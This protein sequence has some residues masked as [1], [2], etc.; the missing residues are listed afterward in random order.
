MKLR[1]LVGILTMTSLMAPL[2][3]GAFPAR[4]QTRTAAG[5][6][7]KEYK[8][9]FDEAAPVSVE[10]F[11]RWSLP[12][13][14]GYMGV[15]VFGGVETEL[16][17]VTEN[18]VFNP[19][20]S[21]KGTLVEDA[22][23]GTKIY[24]NDFG[25]ER[26]DSSSG[27]LNLFAKT[28]IDF[29]G[30]AE[31][32]AVNYRRELS[33]DDSK[34]TVRY[35]IDGTT[36]TREYFSSYPDKVTV[37]RLTAT[38]SGKLNFTLRPE[39]P[40]CYD[41][42]SDEVKYSYLNTPGDGITKTGTVTAAGDTITLKGTMNYFG[43][44][45]EGLYKVIPTGGSMT[46]ANDENGKNGT[47]T[48]EG[49]DSALILLAVGTNYDYDYITFDNA[50][51]MLD[52]A[53]DPHEKV[54]GYLDAAAEK[55]YDQLLAAHLKD[56]RGFFDR[57]DLDLGGVYD[58]TVPTD[59][60]VGSY[61]NGTAA[62]DRYLEELTFQFG[63]YLLIS[64]SREGCLP[65]NLQ[66]IWNYADSAAWS[67][68]YWHNINIQMNYWPAFNT[69]LAE[70]FRSYADYNEAMRERA[71]AN[72]DSYLNAIQSPTAAPAGTGE[73]GY[74]IGTGCNPYKCASAPVTG[75]SGPGTGAFTSLLFWDWY[76]Y[77]MDE[78]VL[79]DH[80]YPAV[81]G[82]A[83]FLSKTL[84]E[85]E[86]GKWLV[87]NS[88]SP[89]NGVNNVYVQS[90]G[91]AFDQQMVYANHMAV[92][93]A[94]EAL[95]YTEEDAPIL[96]VIRE[97]IDRL[98]PVNIGYSGQV[99]EYREENYYGEFGEKNHRHISQLV[100]VYPA[101]V[102]NGDTKAWLDA[103]AVSLENRGYTNIGWGVIHRMLCW[104]R[105]HDGEKAFE[106]LQLMM[107]EHLGYSL[108]SNY[109]N[110]TYAK[111]A[112]N[113]FQ[114]EANF[115]CTAA[116]AEM[117]VQS[118][119]GYLEF[120][121]ALPETWAN[122]SFRGLTTRGNFAVDAVW[123]NG[124]AETLGI[125]SGSGGT[126]KV[127]Y[128]NLANAA[129]KDSAGDPV[130]F[131]VESRD[132]ISFETAAG[133]TYTIT[134]IPSHTPGL[135]AP[136]E[137]TLT[138]DTGD[139]MTL[140]WT[141][142]EGASG[143]NVYR[144]VNDAPDYELV[145]EG[146]TG[147]GY[148]YE[149]TD[150]QGKD[151]VTLRVTAVAPDGTESKSALAYSLPVTAAESAV[152]YLF[153]E[154]D[155]QLEVEA[156]ENATE[157]RAYANGAPVAVSPY[158]VIAVRN[159][160]PSAEYSVSAVV[161]GRESA[162]VRAAV[163]HAAGEDNVLLNRP[164]TLEGRSNW[165]SGYEG[166]YG[167][168]GD[169][170][171]PA[172]WNVP[173][174]WSVSSG[175]SPYSVTADLKGICKL[176]TMKI[177][178]WNSGSDPATRSPNT[179]VEVLTPEGDWVTVREGFPLTK[180]SVTAVEMG[181][182]LASKVRWTFNNDAYDPSH[183][184]YSATASIAE[185]T[186]TGETIDAVNKID[187]LEAVCDYAEQNVASSGFTG[188]QVAYLLA[189]P[190][191]KRVLADKDADQD[192]V[193]KAARAL[194]KAAVG[195][196]L[197]LDR[198]VV[199]G[200]TVISDNYKMEYMVDGDLSTRMA[201]SGKTK[202]DPMNIG[203]TVELDGLYYLDGVFVQEFLNN[204]QRTEGG[205]VTIEVSANG[206]DWTTVL[207]GGSLREYRDGVPASSCSNTAFFFDNTYL[208]DQVRIHFRDA[209]Q[210]STAKNLTLLELQASGEK[211]D[212]D[213]LYLSSSRL[214]LNS[215]TTHSL[216]PSS[217]EVTWTSSDPGVVTVDAS[218]TLTAV[219]SGKAAV[220][221]ADAGGNTAVCQVTVV[222]DP[223]PLEQAIRDA[224]A[225]LEG[226]KGIDRTPDRVISGTKFVPTQRLTALTA[227][228][229][230]A[231]QDLL[232]ANSA[233]QIGSAA[234][235]L[236]A[237]RDRFLAALQ[238][239]TMDLTHH[240]HCVCTGAQD[241]EC[242][243]VTWTAWG[244][245]ETERSS[246]PVT[247]G[248][249]FLVDDIRVSQEYNIGN[250]QPSVTVNLC[251][252]GFDVIGTHTNAHVYNVYST[253]NLCDCSAEENWGKIS[254]SYTG[255]AATIQL[256]DN[257]ENRGQ[258]NFYSGIITAEEGT[259]G[260]D[261][262]LI[263][264]GN[265][266]TNGSV[267]NLYG[268]K[269]CGGRATNGGA[270]TILSKS[271]L[272]VYGGS[273]ADHRANVGGAFHVKGTLNVFRGVI[274]GSK[275]LTG[276]ANAVIYAE[277]TAKLVIA[278]GTF[279]NG[280]SVEGSTV[281]ASLAPGTV[282]VKDADDTV[283]AVDDTM[284]DTGDGSVTVRSGAWTED[285]GDMTLSAATVSYDGVTDAEIPTATVTFGASTLT[286][287]VDYTVRYQRDGETTSDLNTP[288]TVT[289]V[290]SALAPYSGERTATYVI[291]R[292]GSVSEAILSVTERASRYDQSTVTA[293]DRAELAALNAEIDR[294]LT[295]CETVLTAEEKADLA[296]LKVT[297]KEL[298][299]AACLSDP[300]LVRIA[301]R[302]VL[303]QSK[304]EAR[305]LLE[306][307]VF[308]AYLAA[309]MTVTS[310]TVSV[311]GAD[312][313][314]LAFV[315]GGDV[316]ID[317]SG[318]AYYFYLVSG[319]APKD[320]DTAIVFDLVCDLNGTPI[321]DHYEDS[322][323]D[324]LQ[325]VLRSSLS[326]PFKNAARA[327]LQYAQEAAGIFLP[328]SQKDYLNYT[329]DGVEHAVKAVADA[330]RGET[331]TEQ[332]GG[333]LT[334]PIRIHGTSL[335]LNDRIALK[336]WADVRGTGYAALAE[337]PDTVTV[338]LYLNG[339]LNETL[340]VQRKI[341][342]GS[343]HYWTFE[344]GLPVRMT[345]DRVTIELYENGEAISN[346]FTDSVWN[347]AASCFV[348]SNGMTAA[349]KAVAQ[350]MINY[351]FYTVSYLDTL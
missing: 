277:P 100:G 190:E 25:D 203:V 286:E 114:I 123:E 77:T 7:E 142:V 207:S 121:P 22:D 237:E 57:V 78:T 331:M 55:S 36:Y 144:A 186:C 93:Q 338:K 38:G 281:K 37:M 187:L 8:I 117:L 344:I 266:N 103:A 98:D 210:N 82:M 213:G 41:P 313:V 101:D 348:D 255:S 42:E 145:A 33:L 324:A 105:I 50:R 295:D 45:F 177:Y 265:S 1:R 162:A 74:V 294:I 231:E 96:S 226:V 311:N 51:G 69:G 26:I 109:N 158:P 280:L 211:A 81:E 29:A 341:N 218:G 64:S 3:A 179:K 176:G 293:D 296:A 193:D 75:H 297:V 347:Y 332:F 307:E 197:F 261:C 43:T 67:G 217:P 304:L 182:V 351:I 143:Y 47:I 124:V 251:L 292:D 258:M 316:F 18:S 250:D 134:D 148:T 310:F 301:G 180:N 34:A 21:G 70:L 299:D 72:A 224:R 60:L 264:L 136:K 284:T 111:A 56:Y 113:P 35:D 243:A 169:T 271:T 84:K 171:I 319:I 303:F 229:A 204:A 185:I 66:G 120:L 61:G 270:F 71:Q 63:R 223:A 330:E 339:V 23:A 321:T 58:D 194:T 287:G 239:G 126:C 232:T 337:I 15:N 238:T 256:R 161:N 44:D 163:T 222:C 159:A 132:L 49:A 315:I 110:H 129:V 200:V 115:G 215:G 130:P 175:H 87:Y 291:V 48:V 125:T 269:I 73:N 150:I 167:V 247:S 274:G 198:P 278:G 335:L 90:E 166:A 246:L 13:G 325:D 212:T 31:G 65:A 85:Y 127:K 225:S 326:E 99:K 241:H 227:A 54:K 170:T 30:H 314:D 327:A 236:T 323:K 328:E 94:A 202:P 275:D 228:V 336:F 154:N 116:V 173:G 20:S 91:T 253:L 149:Y 244:D 214:T 128:P 320:L 298:E 19:S 89:E 345:Q 76:E 86:D 4:A 240:V 282:P 317:G 350:A 68:G 160:D 188:I 318:T 263:R 157:Y 306:K 146:V 2:F 234:A 209:Y 248:N 183:A 267:F 88:K 245:D 80:A 346:S 272:N 235:A 340:E 153:E 5:D 10:G 151:R 259:V 133:E 230:Q 11:E 288:G 201:V 62:R 285:S 199:S 165:L 249:Y 174:R 220:T 131:T 14:N 119:A 289:V 349:N 189:E 300:G 46:A 104:A 260:T 206:G 40:F 135:A 112:N 83:K 39:I 27:G 168:D 268:G 92:L 79:R 191:A 276:A 329:V 32:S 106:Q 343:L 118:Q 53:P 195:P 24:Y 196:N 181:G 242:T 147:T 97:Q 309:G 233:A 107:A 164:L 108:L 290:A 192:A 155:L 334:A 302:T 140:E 102:I 283:V 122:G 17:S 156:V 184:L 152:G 138:A 305:Y 221:A 139:R 205:D 178:E 137:L 254:G 28:Y 9:W 59:A 257:R 172:K 52:G 16:I 95:G 208:A 216:T 262:G 219:G 312:P 322:L 308:D 12:L 273:I 141:A 252:N 279:T 6:G 333:D 342:S